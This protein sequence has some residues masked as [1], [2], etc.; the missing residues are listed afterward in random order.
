[1]RQ[2]LQDMLASLRTWPDASG[3]RRTGIE[4]LWALPVMVGFAFLY[5]MTTPSRAAPSGVELLRLAAILLIAPA[6]GEELL[7]RAALIPRERPRIRWFVLSVV[8]FVIWHPLQAVTFGPPWSAMFLDL[9]F[10]VA[11]AVLGTALARIYAATRSIWPCVLV[12][13]AVVLSWKALLGGPF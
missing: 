1:M 9:G 6:F 11:V 4:M 13:W 2:R 3:W 8:L 5:D 7:F 10:L 12:H